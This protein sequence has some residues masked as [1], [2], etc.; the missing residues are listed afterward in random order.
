MERIFGNSQRSNAIYVYS[1]GYN[2]LIQYK[3]EPDSLLL[4]LIDILRREILFVWK[5]CE[6]VKGWFIIYGRESKIFIF[7]CRP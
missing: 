7:Q 1:K 5:L 2:F 6:I 3:F 4:K